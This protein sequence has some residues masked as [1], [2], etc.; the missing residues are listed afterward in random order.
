MRNSSINKSREIHYAGRIGTLTPAPTQPRNIHNAT[1]HWGART[2]CGGPGEPLPH[3]TDIIH[4]MYSHPA[5]LTATTT[6]PSQ[7]GA[8]GGE[9]S[10]SL[11]P[12]ET[13][14]GVF[15]RSTHAGKRISSGGTVAAHCSPLTPE[16]ASPPP[17]EPG[18]AAPG[19]AHAIPP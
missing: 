12:S 13:R 7:L 18:V 1:A 17:Q 10:N 4:P 16:P 9:K 11:T 19:A 6:K 8:P 5:L 2:P 14:Y 3:N 15:T